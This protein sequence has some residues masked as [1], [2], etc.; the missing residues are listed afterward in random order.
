MPPAPRPPTDRIELRPIGQ[1]RTAH[2]RLEDTPIQTSRNPGEPGRLVVLEQYAA[3]LD[4]LEGFD[5]AHLICFLDQVW[6]AD[7][8]GTRPFAGDRLRPVPF[9]L[10]H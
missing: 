3:A 5:Y 2:R 10:Q 4:G 8:R 7:G 9:L 6:E 1:V